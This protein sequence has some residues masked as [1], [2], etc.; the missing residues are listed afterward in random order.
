M[1]PSRYN[2]LFSPQGRQMRSLVADGPGRPS[3]E[4]SHLAVAISSDGVV[5]QGTQHPGGRIAHDLPLLVGQ[6]CCA[7]FHNPGD[8]WQVMDHPWCEPLARRQER[9]RLVRVTGEQAA[10]GR[11]PRGRRCHAPEYGLRWGA[12]PPGPRWV[13]MALGT[14]GRRRARAVNIGKSAS[15]VRA[16]SPSRPWTA[17]HPGAG[18]ESH[19]TASQHGVIASGRSD[20]ETT[21]ASTAGVTLWWATDRPAQR[22]LLPICCLGRAIRGRSRPDWAADL[23]W[24]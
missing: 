18:F 21:P 10:A 13:R 8:P 5:L 23:G 24:S 2:F 19:L 12:G 9:M 20:H 6:L 11:A 16:R 17:K 3:A 15:Q 4:L 7:V 22:R 14:A 1:V